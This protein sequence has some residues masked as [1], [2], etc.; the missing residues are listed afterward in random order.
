[1]VKYLNTQL[2]VAQQAKRIDPNGE[3]AVIAELLEKMN[4]FLIDAPVIRANK[5]TDHQVSRRQAMP[6]VGTRIANQGIDPTLSIVDQIKEPVIHLETLIKMDELIIDQ[7]KDPNGA[8]W[9]EVKAHLEAFIQQFSTYT[10]YGR[11]A[12]GQVDGMSVRYNSL[13]LPNVVSIGGSGSDLT[14]MLMCEWG[15]RKLHFS[16]PEFGTAGVEARNKGKELTTDADSKEYYAYIY[17]VLLDFGL[18]V[19]DSRAIQRLANIESD[20]A[21]NNLIDQ[22]KARDIVRARGRLPKAGEAATIIYANRDLKSQF[23]IWAL[24]KANGFYMAK[25]ISGEPMATFQG[26]PIR[27]LEAILSTES[28]VS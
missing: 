13:A 14:S 22:T 23:D 4:E 10:V 9:N 2:T 20:G 12:L 18:T 6:T 28:A 16:Y 1:M 8:Q 25:N 21:T 3:A 15:E 11:R 26:M 19:A 5:G 24:E 17:Q 27:M 7:Q